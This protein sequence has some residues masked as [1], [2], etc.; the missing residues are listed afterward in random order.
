LD[1]K[2]Y[3]LKH[4]DKNLIEFRFIKEALSSPKLEIIN[5]NQEYKQFFPLGLALNNDSLLFWIKSRT[6]IPKNRNFV[7]KLLE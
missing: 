3:I 2:T 7:H 5:I 1:T 6:T 4:F